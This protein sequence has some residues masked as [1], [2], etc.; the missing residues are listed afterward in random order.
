MGFFCITPKVTFKMAGENH[1]DSNLTIY[2][3]VLNRLPFLEDSATNTELISNF[4]LEVMWELEVCFKI[5]DKTTPSNDAN[6]GQEDFYTTIQK[7]IIADILA[8]YIL[9][10]YAASIAGGGSLTADMDSAPSNTF[11]KT[12]KAGSVSVEWSQFN[13]SNSNSLAV[14]NDKLMDR[15]KKAAIR[16][17]KSVGCIID[18]CD[19][20]SMTA[21]IASSNFTKPFVVI[22]SCGL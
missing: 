15:Y 9:L 22:K 5:K 10:V 6:V 21:Q 14:G 3:M 19:D 8:V 17:A 12:V 13:V 20:C 18:I 7:T 4:T 11:I 1:N 16:K 2:K